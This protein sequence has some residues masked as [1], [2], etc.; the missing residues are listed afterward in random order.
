MWLLQQWVVYFFSGLIEEYKNVV[1][2]MQSLTSHTT[3]VY[4]SKGFKVMFSTQ[5]RMFSVM[6]NVAMR[7]DAIRDNNMHK[8]QC[9]GPGHRA[10]PWWFPVCFSGSVYEQ[11]HYCKQLVMGKS[12]WLWVQ[13]W[14]SGAISWTVNS[15]PLSVL[16]CDQELADSRNPICLR[17]RERDQAWTTRGRGDASVHWHKVQWP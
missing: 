13:A 14:M 8:E 11:I 9:I 10:S 5:H 6:L 16:P 4:L 1:Y 15:L 3:S 7:E 17:E 12:M 2:F